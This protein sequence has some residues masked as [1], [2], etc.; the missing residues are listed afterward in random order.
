MP[1]IWERG[2]EQVRNQPGGERQHGK[3]CFDNFCFG[4]ETTQ[5]SKHS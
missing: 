4:L 5:P 2:G 3:L 1:K